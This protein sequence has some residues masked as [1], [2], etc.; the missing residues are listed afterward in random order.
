MVGA[1]ESGRLVTVGRRFEVVRNR[2]LLTLAVGHMTVD[3]YAG[4]LPMMYPLL[5][6]KFALDL[7]TVGMVA[8]AY[9]AGS[10]L[11]Q[12]LFGWLADR[13][14]TRYIG[15]ALSWT[16]I[17]FA[18]LGFVPNFAV[19]VALAALSG[20]GSGAYHPMGALNASA[21]ISEARRNSAMSIYTTGGTLGI[22]TGPLIGVLTLGA[23]GLH[24]TIFMLIPGLLIAVVLL[25][26]M[27]AIALRPRRTGGS[28]RLVPPP[29]PIGPISV[30]VGVMMLRAWSV[31][32][33]QAFI[34]IWY[35]SMGYEPSFYG[36]LATTL[37][38]ANVIGAIG[39][40]HLADRFG[41]RILIV[42]STILSVPALL[43]FAQ[44]PGSIAFVTAA[45]IGLLAASTTP[46][47]LVTA[48]QLM[49]G[50]AG[51][52][53]GLV[54][55]LGFV[56]GAIGVPILGAVG[57]AHGIQNAMRLLALIAAA[58]ASVAAFLPSEELVRQFANRNS[59]ALPAASLPTA[60]S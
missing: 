15:L 37:V 11:S 48:Q 21:V 20:I 55:G 38:L 27:R 32:G 43:L 14:G 54:L 16:A 36:L 28:P 26:E 50:R 3:M 46:L 31:F 17:T 29:V 60:S 52:A 51:M 44:F 39:A 1:E 57:D 40:G 25:F 45:A 18:L 7:K 42:G 4:L 34:P 58:S 24:G 35:A 56:M 47:L 22:A 59:N 41:R 9:G 8:L 12:P 10:S 23:F 19:L 33:L 6:G 2:P 30:V 5:A 49:V 13:H 53:S